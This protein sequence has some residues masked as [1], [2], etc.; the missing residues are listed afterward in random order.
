MSAEKK[1]LWCSKQFTPGHGNSNYCSQ[2]CAIAAK[3]ERQKAKRDPI[4]RFIPILVANHEKLES[5]FNEGTIELSREALELH[6]IDISLVRYLKPPPEHH[7]YLM[8]DF[9]VFY[10]ITNSTFLNFKIF[11]HE[12]TSP[13]SSK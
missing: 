9:G 7:A 5:L 11:K 6:Q 4:A 3:A 10:M 8:L 1:C 2:E 13:V 12:T